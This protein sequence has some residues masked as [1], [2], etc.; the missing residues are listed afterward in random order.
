MSQVRSHVNDLADSVI[1]DPIALRAQL[2]DLQREYPARIAE[3]SSELD[4]LTGQISNLERERRITARAH[5]IAQAKAAEWTDMLSRAKDAQGN[6]R[7][8]AFQYDNQTFN[9]EQ[10]VA[11]A[12]SVRGQ[13]NL[14]AKRVEDMDRDLTFLAQQHQRLDELLKQL[15]TE[16][17]QLHTQIAQLDSEIDMIERNETLIT[18]IEDREQAINEYSTGSRGVSIAQVEKRLAKIHA[19]Q[20]ARFNAITGRS[21]NS[22]FLDQA[23]Q[24][25][26]HEDAVDELEQEYSFEVPAP[27]APKS[28]TI[29][30]P[31]GEHQTTNAYAMN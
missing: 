27:E 5:T 3:I 10:A 20:E 8:V 11:R 16:Q 4:T 29:I 21:K 15:E 31:K 18:M 22:S 2:R 7:T 14:F 19:E 23:E 25:L 12:Q 28:M 6:F 13:V 17:D 24:E 30:T 1:D 26:M 9:F